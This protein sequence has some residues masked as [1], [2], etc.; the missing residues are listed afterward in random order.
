MN[1]T[2]YEAAYKDAAGK[3]T[4]LGFLA[5]KTAIGLLEFVQTCKCA[6]ELV[7]AMPE[8]VVISR[9]NCGWD[10]ETAAGAPFGRFYFTGRTERDAA[11]EAPK[12]RRYCF[13]G[14]PGVEYPAALPGYPDHV[15]VL[16]DRH[17]SN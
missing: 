6:Q 13:C 4:P 7:E 3:V 16:C 1:G 17:A 11:N 14:A 15:S 8:D 12:P 5:R 2:K 10:V 9:A